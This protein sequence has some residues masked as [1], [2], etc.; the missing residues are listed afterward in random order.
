MARPDDKRR[1]L[2]KKMGVKG[3]VGDDVYITTNKIHRGF[4]KIAGKGNHLQNA[5]YMKQYL[6]PATTGAPTALAIMNEPWGKTIDKENSVDRIRNTVMKTYGKI[7][8]AL[9]GSPL[10]TAATDKLV[11]IAKDYAPVVED[12]AKSIK[13]GGLEVDRMNTLMFA[14]RNAMVDSI[15][16]EY[17]KAQEKLPEEDRE[18]ISKDDIGA[19]FATRPEFV[20]WMADDLKGVQE[21]RNTLTNTEKVTKAIGELE[22]HSGKQPG[23]LRSLQNDTLQTIRELH[24]MGL[25]NEKSLFKWLK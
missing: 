17:Q 24:K 20:G 13:N 7:A 21:G 11:D 4:R 3:K 12:I 1:S 14:F 9:F 15:L 5:G 18:P 23:S 10:M 6:G 19:L 2:A 25:L 22:D 16:E 8:K